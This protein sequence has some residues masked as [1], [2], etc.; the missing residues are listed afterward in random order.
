MQDSL[1]HSLTARAAIWARSVLILAMVCFLSSCGTLNFGGREDV[2]PALSGGQEA[3]REAA[4]E[5][6]ET[7]WPKPDKIS[8]ATRLATL[9]LNG[10]RGSEEDPKRLT[11]DDAARAYVAEK[12]S[13]AG[14]PGPA[15]RLVFE[16]AR[17]TLDLAD[18][19]LAAAE[20]IAAA[21]LE[22]KLLSEDVAYLERS[23]VDLRSHRDMYQRIFAELAA[24]GETPLSSLAVDATLSAF[25]Q[26][27][28][29]I[30][31]AADELV[32]LSRAERRKEER[33][34]RSWL[35]GR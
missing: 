34:V 23:I 25:S 27:A 18:K 15:V 9:L 24:K 14:A 32:R 30:G 6:G 13:D 20:D 16:D 19:V 8:A 12:I 11:P 26:S 21:R 5:L 22:A 4:A 33:G 35:L 28:I 29:D 7:P 1:A 2:A 17:A 10:D 31:V 3:L